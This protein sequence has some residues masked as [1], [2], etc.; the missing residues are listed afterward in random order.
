MKGGEQEHP[1]ALNQ[2]CGRQLEEGR[3]EINET[4]TGNP[5]GPSCDLGGNHFFHHKIP[6]EDIASGGGVET[7]SA[8]GKVGV[9]DRIRQKRTVEELIDQHL[10]GDDL[11]GISSAKPIILAAVEEVH[12]HSESGP[13]WGCGEEVPKVC[14]Q[15]TAFLKED[16][17]EQLGK[18]SARDD[19]GRKRKPVTHFLAHLPHPGQEGRGA[20]VEKIGCKETKHERLQEKARQEVGA[21]GTETGLECSAKIQSS[22]DS[23]KRTP[24]RRRAW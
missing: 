15:E 12:E 7:R 5:N 22:L 23:K 2:H 20:I 17:A 13:E 21:G 18:K 16:N 1:E 14:T 8:E 10:G 6:G 19:V 24:L 4:D 3:H 9:G 11:P